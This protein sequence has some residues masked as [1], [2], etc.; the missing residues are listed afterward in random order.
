MNAHLNA[1]G[2]PGASGTIQ[3]AH[4]V[5][6]AL[7][8][9]FPSEERS[10]R[11]SHQ[12]LERATFRDTSPSLNVIQT[13]SAHRRFP[14][15]PPYDQRFTEWNEEQEEFARHKACKIHKE[16]FKIKGY[17][18]EVHT[19]N[20]F[21]S[22]VPAEAKNTATGLATQCKESVCAVDSGASSHL[23]GLSSL[24]HK[25]KKP[26]RQSSEILNI[27]TAICIVVSDTPA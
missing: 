15:A 21:R 7:E 20:F 27:Q 14:N 2:K 12:S 9:T 5:I 23:M 6:L 13:G 18:N 24:N 26:I 8:R 10:I 19:T 1:E 4:E 11:F 25:G 17:S 3:N 22:Y 16:L